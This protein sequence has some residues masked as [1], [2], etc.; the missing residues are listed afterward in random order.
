MCTT[1][2]EADEL[3][4]Y[5][6]RLFGLNSIFDTFLASSWIGIRKPAAMFYERALAITCARAEE[7]VFIDDRE[8]NLVAPRA[9][10]FHAI[11][12]ESADQLR[13]ELGEAGLEFNIKTG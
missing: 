6:I 5:R 1:S 11:H 10:G 2:N 8:E 4:R 13:R 9:L 7:S 12:F 3:S